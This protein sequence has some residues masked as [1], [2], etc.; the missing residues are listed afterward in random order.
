MSKV[1]Q[2]SFFPKQDLFF[3]GSLLKK[4]HAR[5][6]RPLSSKKALHIVLKSDQAVWTK[7][8]DLRL[9]SK[10]Q[11]IEK[12]LTDQLTKYGIKL[13]NF[14][15]AINHIHLLIKF[16]SRAK[17]LSWIK[18]ITGLI[19]RKMLLAE[20][21][22]PSKESFLT[23]RP[24]TRIV[25]WGKDFYGVIKYIEQN[26]LEALGVIS[27]TVREGKKNTKE[28][29][30]KRKSEKAQTGNKNENAKIKQDLEKKMK[31]KSTK[32]AG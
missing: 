29:H 4:A 5:S 6:A 9:S 7:E 1:K 11:V 23:H 26:I 28:M 30:A 15:I 10:K 32:K 12:I 31:K 27:Y 2:Q 16:N 13:Y 21:G 17:Y 18:R 24:F 25:K 22:S 19:A 8:R 14:A 20:R 3:G